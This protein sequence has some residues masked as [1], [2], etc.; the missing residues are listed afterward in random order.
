MKNKTVHHSTLLILLML[1]NWSLQ[2]LAQPTVRPREADQLME[3]TMLI[4]DRETYCVEENIFFSAINISSF[5]LRNANW[6]NVLYIELISPDGTPF[7]QR[8]YAYNG[9][10]ST[11]VLKIPRD[12]LTG[13][14]YLRAYTRWMRN[15][16]PSNYFYKMITVINPYRPELFE[17][18]GR[19]GKHENALKPMVDD[20]SNLSIK[21]EKKCFSKREQVIME[22]SASN[23][24]GYMG[25][26]TVSV[27]PKG[28]EIPLNPMISGPQ[29]MSFSPEF[30]PETRGLSISGKVINANDSLPIPYTQVALTI[31]KENSG[32]R[33]VMTNDKG[34]FFFDL[35]KL[36]GV[37]EILLSTKSIGKQKPLILVDNDFATRTIDLPFVPVNLSE[38]SKK[39]YQLLTFN[40]QMQ[41]L[42]RQQKMEEKV[43]TF[44]SDTSF[45]GSPD[46]VLS[47]KEF[48]ALPTL[49]D[50]ITELIPQVGIRHADKTTALKVLGPEPE[51]AVYEPMVLIDMV[52]I[53]D[54]DR[55]LEVPPAKIERIEVVT[56][57][58]VRGDIIYGGIISFI[59]KKG[60]LAGIDIPSA[61]QFIAYRML[62][63]Q[64]S[65]AEIP[66]S[67]RIPDIRNC[68]YWNPTLKLDEKKPVQV[69]F[70]AGDNPGHYLIVVRG[71]DKDANIKVSTGEI[72]IH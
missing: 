13:N 70:N 39:M 6:S 44:S 15:Y 27:I 24:E 53:F 32:P 26:V 8:K 10:G 67:P 41:Q 31:F 71:L 57:P 47:M 16:S 59:S 28:T 5:P 60:D 56:K 37:Y 1:V 40:N 43:E 22:I 66:S 34:Q 42:Y 14:Y 18:Q 65:Q 72:F 20:S 9:D 49:T 69:S 52:S 51:L 61:G 7:S 46:F 11:G 45:Y 33:T 68:L 29:L 48:I 19:T 38:D 36:K 62:N 30:I 25:P 4:T 55:I 50:Y 58:Y 64:I 17:L 2:G 23:T 3:K 21:T 54:I 63:N 35:A 12:L